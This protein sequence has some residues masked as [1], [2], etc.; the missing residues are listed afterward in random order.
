MRL[1]GSRIRK[2]IKN[3]EVIVSN[4]WIDAIVFGPGDLAA[5]MGLHGQWE[6]QDVISA[7]GKVVQVALEN[8]KSVEALVMASNREQYLDQQAMGIQIF[9]STRSNEYNLLRKGASE[10]IAPFLPEV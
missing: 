6:H 7:M 2:G 3:A 1:K 4:P 10:N 9:G 8:E 5:D